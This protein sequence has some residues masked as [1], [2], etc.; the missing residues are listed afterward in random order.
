MRHNYRT[1]SFKRHKLS[2]HTVY[3]HENFR[4]YSWG[5]AV[6]RAQKEAHVWKCCTVDQNFIFASYWLQKFRGTLFTTTNGTSLLQ[7]TQLSLIQIRCAVYLQAF[8]ICKKI[9]QI[10]GGPQLPYQKSQENLT[11]KRTPEDFPLLQAITGTFCDVY[12]GLK[13][14]HNKVLLAFCMGRLGKMRKLVK[15]DVL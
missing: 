12:Q 15:V 9:G 13:A 3:L 10:I 2:Q 4:Q 1:P 11:S 6:D 14:C 5:N 7:M 8:T